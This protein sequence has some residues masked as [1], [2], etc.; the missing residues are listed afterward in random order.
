MAST[1]AR[2]ELIGVIAAAL[3]KPCL[4]RGLSHHVNE[5][6]SG[7]EDVLKALFEYDSY[8]ASFLLFDK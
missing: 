6:T 2:D 1:E 8:L 3:H 4:Q 7:A 5:H